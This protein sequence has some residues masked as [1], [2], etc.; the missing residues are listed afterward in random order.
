LLLASAL[1]AGAGCFLRREAKAA[2]TYIAPSNLAASAFSVKIDDGGSTRTFR[3]VEMLQEAGGRQLSTPVIGTATS[4]TLSIEYTIE[5]SSAIVSKGVV[6]M[7]LRDDWTWGARIEVD[8]INP[9]RYCFG[10][11]GSKAFRL[12]AAYR[13][14]PADSVWVTW[15]GNSIKNPVV[16]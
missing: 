11:F 2:V 13:R 10:C 6:T 16:Y 5:T 1:L 14:V 3:G 7:A 15:G 12:A 9:A 4:G 8:S